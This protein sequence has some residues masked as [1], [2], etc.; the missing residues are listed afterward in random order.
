MALTTHPNLN[1]EIKER[2]E[3]YLYSPSV[4]SWQVIRR[5]LPL[6]YKKVDTENL[7]MF[8]LPHPHGLI[9]QAGLDLLIAEVSISHS[10]HTTF[11][12]TPLD[13]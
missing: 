6:P 3:L 4:L 8:L 5:K 9:A 11:S 12:R 7:C 1:A 13:E 10:R 2:V